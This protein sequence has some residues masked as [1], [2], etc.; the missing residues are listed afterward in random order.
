MGAVRKEEGAPEERMTPL[1]DIPAEYGMRIRIGSRASIACAIAALSVV[2]IVLVAREDLSVLDQTSVAE[3]VDTQMFPSDGFGAPTWVASNNDNYNPIGSM[4]MGEDDGLEDVITSVNNH[5]SSDD[6]SGGESAAYLPPQGNV[7]GYDTQVP[8][9]DF[10]NQGTE[11]YMA[12]PFAPVVGG[13][14]STQPYDTTPLSPPSVT[15]AGTDFQPTEMINSADTARNEQPKAQYTP[16]EAK[17]LTGDGRH[18]VAE[19]AELHALQH[20]GAATAY[21]KAVIDA[22]KNLSISAAKRAEALAKVIAAE[23]KHQTQTDTKKSKQGQAPAKLFVKTSQKSQKSPTE[24]PKKSKDKQQDLRVHELAQKVAELTQ[25]NKEKSEAQSLVRKKLEDQKMRSAD[26]RKKFAAEKKA[27]E[28]RLEVEKKLN[29]KKLQA[30]KASE[31]VLQHKLSSYRHKVQSLPVLQHK[32][33]S[34][35]HK[36]KSLQHKFDAE[37]N[38]RRK[39]QSSRRQAQS[40][41]MLAKE[42]ANNA[43]QQ[44]QSAKAFAE[45]RYQ[46]EHDARIKAENEAARAKKEA[47]AAKQEAKMA[48]HAQGHNTKKKVAQMTRDLRRKLDDTKKEL[49]D[50]EQLRFQRE[51][52]VEKMNDRLKELSHS[53]AKASTETM[54]NAVM[55]A[56]QKAQATFSK[57]L[58]KSKDVSQTALN[59]AIESQRNAEH[60]AQQAEEEARAAVKAEF[61]KKMKAMK[62]EMKRNYAEQLKVTKEASEKHISSV[63]KTAQDQMHKTSEDAAHA[64]IQA[65]N[66][67]AQLQAAKTK[68]EHDEAK[69]KN[70]KQGSPT[71]TL[72]ATDGATLKSQM[73][74]MLPHKQFLSQTHRLCPNKLR[75]RSWCHLRTQRCIQRNMKLRRKLQIA[76]TRTA[77]KKSQHTKRML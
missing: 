44:G 47:K 16:A 35:R 77:R 45:S 31:A 57:K 54:K 37:Q 52:D 19:T 49:H 12:D 26:V 32:L 48:A 24:V 73:Q 6:G 4:Q 29:E 66:Y 30:E 70:R 3:S 18:T 61:T 64:E 20:Q 41:V 56:L 33:S 7:Q 72:L 67:E 22:K 15:G 40:Q 14:E 51:R 63:L 5:I 62:A 50:E 39:E 2:A 71:D 42:A 23:S 34:Y 1:S 36:V 11:N 69:L 76:W 8:Q 38:T 60:K 17:A 59:A 28:T 21:Q 53:P 9:M 74:E 46:M 75:Q 58:Q 10:A 27:I 68:A 25:A 13:G 43:K 55:L 65:A